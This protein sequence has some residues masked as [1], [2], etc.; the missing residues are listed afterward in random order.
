[1]WAEAMQLLDI[2]FKIMVRRASAPVFYGGQGRPRYQYLLV[3][4]ES[5]CMVG[6]AY[7]NRC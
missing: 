2:G 3:V 5:S 1:M 6:T 4:L 7:Q